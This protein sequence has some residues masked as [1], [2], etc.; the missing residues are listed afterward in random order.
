MY[1]FPTLVTPPSFDFARFLAWDGFEASLSSLPLIDRP[2]SSVFDF[3]ELAEAASAAFTN[4][5]VP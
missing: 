2:S 1:T 4:S 3:L 5:T